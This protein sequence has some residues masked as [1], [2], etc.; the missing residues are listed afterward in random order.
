MLESGGRSTQENGKDHP[1]RGSIKV[2]LE[3][4]DSACHLQ[5][6]IG[7][8]GGR[9]RGAVA[10]LIAGKVGQRTLLPI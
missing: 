9:G 3:I 5:G 6:V 8:K 10:D 1:L 4:G 2:F 7:K